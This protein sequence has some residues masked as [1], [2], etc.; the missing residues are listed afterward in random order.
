MSIFHALES[1]AS[2]LTA[3]RLRMDVISSNIANAQ[4]TRA[5]VNENG[6]YEPY[7]RK[8]V[9][10]QSESTNFKSLLN[11]AKN[12]GQPG[13]VKV[14]DIT[15]DETP[16][17]FVYNPSHPDANENGYVQLPNVEPLKEMVD[18][19][20]ATRSYEANITALNASK[21]MLMKALEIGK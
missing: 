10:M 5:T 18:L 13:G 3:Q 8:M 19:M 21:S 12:S 1:S 14:T 17:K 11:R 6:D 15:E 16:F 20:S 7:R 2:A 4:S 9:T